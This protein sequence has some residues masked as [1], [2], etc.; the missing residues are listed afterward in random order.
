M[1]N[2]RGGCN[3]RCIKC[4]SNNPPRSS[5]L[6]FKIIQRI[7]S[8]ARD[9]GARALV[10]AGEGEPI[11]APNFR[12]V[13]RYANQQNLITIIFT[14]ASYLNLENINFLYNHDCSLIV[15]FDSLQKKTY[16]KLAGIPKVYSKAKRNLEKCRETY[17][18]YITSADSV[19]IVRL[20][21][22]TAVCKDNHH[23]IPEIHTYCRDDILFVCNYIARCGSAVR[24]WQRLCGTEKQ[25]IKLKALTKKY[26]ETGG[27]SA[28]TID[29]K[30]AYLYYG[31]GIASDGSVIPCAYTQALIGHLENIKRN[32][33]RKVLHSMKKR[34][35]DYHSEFGEESCILRRKDYRRFVKLQGGKTEDGFLI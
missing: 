16:E 14:N 11:A 18:S 7:I 9:L 32:P 29:N 15:S 25:Y 22:N 1:L 33:L 17:K 2:L 34:I 4:F 28:L 10:I 31:I 21:I 24:Y 3:Y 13:V 8:E 12:Q 6:S 35:N 19:R 26:S 5:L 20:S 27:S 30:C 23:E